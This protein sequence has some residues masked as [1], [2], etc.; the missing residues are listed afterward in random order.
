VCHTA[1]EYNPWVRIDL[2][3]IVHVLTIAVTNREDARDYIRAI[4]SELRVGNSTASGTA[5]PVCETRDKVDDGGIWNCDLW[6]K[7]VAIR[8][9]R[10]TR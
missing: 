7:H 1:T 8:R 6:G 9:Y 4:G 2:A 10:R 5:N 3:E